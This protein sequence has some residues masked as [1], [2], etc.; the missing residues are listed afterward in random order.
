MLFV[1]Q[2]AT[3]EVLTTREKKS[4]MKQ[5]ADF[6]VTGQVILIT[7]FTKRQVPEF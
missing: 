6:A 4:L 5:N 1:S 7:N 2:M 3:L